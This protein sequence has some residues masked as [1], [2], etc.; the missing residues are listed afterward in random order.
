MSTL[1]QQPFS[2]CS[3]QLD[4]EFNAV[5]LPPRSASATPCKSAEP[6]LVDVS[7][8]R[9]FTLHRSLRPVNDKLQAEEGYD[10]ASDDDCI[11]APS[12]RKPFSTILSSETNSCDQEN[13]EPLEHPSG[14]RS[15]HTRSRTEELIMSELRSLTRPNSVK[16]K[17]CATS[18]HSS[19]EAGPFRG[20]TFTPEPLAGLDGWLSRQ[21]TKE[22]AQ[23]RSD[24]TPRLFRGSS[25]KYHPTQGSSINIV[26]GKPNLCSVSQPNVKVG[27]FSQESIVNQTPKSQ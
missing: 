26:C 1:F 12:P 10:S 19:S 21:T 8:L 9:T 5:Y 27:V 2:N 15:T 24:F 25:Q 11:V 14:T 18:E 4:G 17:A 23:L 20:F 3:G 22:L 16:G 13:E 6:F 7:K